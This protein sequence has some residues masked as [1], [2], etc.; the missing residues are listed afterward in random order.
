MGDGSH[1]VTTN[2]EAEFV[3]AAQSVSEQM[4]NTKHARR[5]RGLACEYVLSEIRLRL[6]LLASTSRRGTFPEPINSSRCSERNTHCSFLCLFLPLACATWESAVAGPHRLPEYLNAE[7]ATRNNAFQS[8]HRYR[9]S[10]IFYAPRQVTLGAASAN[11]QYVRRNKYA[12]V[13]VR[14]LYNCRLIPL[15]ACVF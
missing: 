6:Q 9:P 14:A 12:S 4:S 1:F 8:P 11:I 13:P 7:Y 2:F 5:R 3:S 10:H 15:A